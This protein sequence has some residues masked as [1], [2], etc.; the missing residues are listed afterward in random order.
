[1]KDEKNK[2]QAPVV[3]V[4]G[5]EMDALKQQQNQEACRKKVDKA[6][7]DISKSEKT[8]QLANNEIVRK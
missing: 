7:L 8:R 5:S 6:S 4:P 2:V 3:T 1:M